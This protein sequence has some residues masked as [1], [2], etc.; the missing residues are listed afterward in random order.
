MAMTELPG[1]IRF[2]KMRFIFILLLVASA[3]VRAQASTGG[4]EPG[5]LLREGVWNGDIGLYATPAALQS[6]KPLQWPGDEWH[7][8]R[9]LER[10]VAV[11]AVRAPHGEMPAFLKGIVAQLE[12]P[13]R[14]TQLQAPEPENA[15]FLRVPGVRL[16]QGNLSPYIFRNGTPRLVPKLDHRYEL[17]LGGASFAFKVQNGFRTANGETYGAGALYTIEYGGSK[18]EYVIGTHGWESVVAAIADLDGDGRPDFI[19]IGGM[20]NA[21]YEAVLLSSQARPGR[22]PPTASLT[23]SGC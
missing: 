1:P 22:N 21:S 3:A 4:P 8:I 14:E 19:L 10:S 13:P 2:M 20:S 18:Y 15:L 6:V 17:S 9:I 23:A 5:A 11:E 12:A 16:R 7:R